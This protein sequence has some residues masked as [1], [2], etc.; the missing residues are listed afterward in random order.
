MHAR[1][2]ALFAPSQLPSPL[3]RRCSLIQLLASAF[4]ISWS[5]VVRIHGIRPT[6]RPG[7]PSGVFVANH[8]SMIDYIIMLQ[9]HPY[10]V[11]GQQHAGWVG[12]LQN[13]LL[14]SLH[15]L[16][17]NRGEDKDRRTVADRISRRR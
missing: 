12:V 1:R 8:S 13:Y 5:G 10:A 6:P 4:V 17:F 16:W 3:R 15:C 14:R 11:V 9:T 7:Q 2:R